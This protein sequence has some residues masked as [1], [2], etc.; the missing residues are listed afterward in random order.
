MKSWVFY[1]PPLTSPIPSVAPVEQMSPA[2]RWIPRLLTHWN[3]IWDHASAV[4]VCVH[5]LCDSYVW[6]HL[7]TVLLSVCVL[8]EAERTGGVHL[9]QCLLVG[10]CEWL[11][12]YTLPPGRGIPSWALA[13]A[14][15]ILQNVHTHNAKITHWA[16]VLSS[17]LFVCFFL[18]YN[19]S[20]HVQKEQKF[21]NSLKGHALIVHPSS[22]CCEDIWVHAC[23]VTCV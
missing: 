7:N 5:C 19:F 16:F 18:N 10:V 23:R 17:I 9:C 14:G 13:T 11:L 4:D 1:L 22:K 12:V 20:G 21:C 2:S 15:G 3:T 8:L 6:L